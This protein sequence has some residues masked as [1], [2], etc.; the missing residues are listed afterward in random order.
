MASRAG[1][2]GGM[3][4]GNNNKKHRVHLAIRKRRIS[5]A[6]SSEFGECVVGRT[7]WPQRNV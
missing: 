7:P 6:T 5:G 2:P 3:V 1:A 4:K